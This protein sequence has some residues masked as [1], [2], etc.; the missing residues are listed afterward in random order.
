M[1][2]RRSLRGNS[3]IVAHVGISRPL[4]PGSGRRQFSH[5]A[6]VRPQSL[7]PR[8]QAGFGLIAAP[9]LTVVVRKHRTPLAVVV[10]GGGVNIP[11]FRPTTPRPPPFY[12]WLISK[13]F[14]RTA[15]TKLCGYS[16]LSSSSVACCSSL[17]ASLRRGEC[18]TLFGLFLPVP[19]AV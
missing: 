18:R 2:E 15:Q 6:S 11:T 17:A 8:A 5:V 13:T 14:C 1:A 4:K 19:S 12:R 10:L 16:T 3:R 9:T 7:R